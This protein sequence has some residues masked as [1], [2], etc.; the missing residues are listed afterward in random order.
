MAINITSIIGSNVGSFV[1]QLIARFKADP[2]VAL[3]KSTEL[4]EMQMQLQGKLIDQ[5]TAQIEVD[6]VEAASNS[7]FV[8]GWRPWA[9][10]ICSTSLL[11]PAVVYLIQAIVMLAHGKYD[12][13]PPNTTD[14]SMTLMG[15]LGLG[16]MRSWDKN[17]GTGNGH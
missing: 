16:G 15:L 8:A 14:L 12:V 4:Q 3:E 17:N 13:P 10:W 5:I 2:T 11:I 1:D 7:M 6:K 9:G